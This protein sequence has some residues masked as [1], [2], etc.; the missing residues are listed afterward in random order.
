MQTH[1]EN[2]QT[3]SP[4]RTG[5]SPGRVRAGRRIPRRA[6]RLALLAWDS[7]AW[8]VGLSAGSWLRY[9]GDIAAIDTRGL[10]L[11]LVVALVAQATVA[12][13]L[14]L[15]RGR[16]ST[17]SVE[18]AISVAA[19]AA[20]VGIAVFVVV[21]LPSLP[22]VPRSVPAAGALIALL[23]SVGA[24]VA[25]RRWR[26]R[27][28]R[29][30][31][32]PTHRVI[33]LGAGLEGQQLVRSML[34]DRSHEYLP[35]ALLDDDP[36]LRCR[37]VH[38]VRVRGTRHDITEVAAAT[39]ADLL[40]VASPVLDAAAVHEVDRAATAAGRGGALVVVE[41]RPRRP[42]AVPDRWPALDGEPGHPQ[43]RAGHGVAPLLDEPCGGGPGSGGV[44][45]RGSTGRPRLRCARPR[46]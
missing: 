36:D 25:V 33:V 32:P 27:R 8:V 13:A 20:L 24:R 22:P 17:G 35:V 9:D 41:V 45:R 43:D 40:V 38:G 46:R 23:L 37:L 28:T 44:S 15:Y 34:V 7:A 30:A 16:Y 5:E 11:V 6:R 4:G 12:V 29:S 21:L 26:E 10:A 14:R 3:G 18:D 42:R 31:G 19:T 1:V 2:E 39:G